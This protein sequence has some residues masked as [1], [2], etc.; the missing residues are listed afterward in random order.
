MCRAH[1]VAISVT[2]SI[3][4]VFLVTGCDSSSNPLGGIGD[5]CVNHEDCEAGLFCGSDGLCYDPGGGDG[6]ADG[7]SD[8]DGDVDVCVDND[9]DTF[10]STTTD[11]PTGTDCNDANA[12]I[13]PE[14]EEVCGDSVDNNCDGTVDESCPCII[15]ALR[16]CSSVG[17]PADLTPEMRCQ[18]GV[19]VCEDGFWSDECFGEV[20]PQEEECNG[21]DD[22]CDG[23]VDEGLLNTLG[24]CDDGTPPP[25]EDCGPTGEGNGIDD[26]GDGQVDETCVCS[27]PDYDPEL[28]R[29][30]QPCYSG[31]IYTLGVGV[32]HGGTRDCGSDGVWGPCIG[33]VIPSEEICG[34]AEDEDCDGFVDET[35]PTC[36][37]PT[38]EV[39]DSVDNDCDGL[40]D[41]GVRNPCGGCGLVSDEETCD[42][43][44]D[45]NC[46]GQIDEG[47]GGCVGGETQACYGG[48]PSAAGVGVC[49]LGERTCTGEFWGDCTGW[50]PPG[51]ELCG[52][53]GLGNGVDED[54]DG[55]EDEDCG[56]AD[57][58]TRFCGDAAGWCEYGLETCG[59]GVWGDCSGEV[60]P[61]IEVCDT[62]DNDCDG[63]TDEGLLNACGTC[64]ESC[65]VLPMDPTD[66]GTIDEGVTTIEADDPENPTGRG[67]ITLTRAAFIPPYLWAANH[68]NNTVTKF[69]TDTHEQEAIYWVGANPSRTA[70]DLNGNMWVGGRDDGRLT[71]VMWNTEECPD[72]NGN[73]SVDTSVVDA[74][75]IP[76]LVNSALDPEADECVLYSAVPNPAQPSIRGVAAGPDGRVW[77]G[78][79]GGGVQSIDPA[80]FVLG[81]YFAGD[82]VP[83]YDPDIDGVMQPTPG[84]TYDSGGVY[85][86][87]VD[88]RGFL[89]TSSFN[90]NTLARFNTLTEE[91]DA[92]YVHAGSQCSY[93]IAVDGNDRIWLGGWPECGGV[94]MFDPDSMRFYSFI[95]PS[96]IG[97][98]FPGE[99]TPA[100]VNDG[101]IGTGG[102]STFYVT[103]V[104]VEPATGDVWC[105]FYPIGYTGRLR[106]NEADY[107]SSSWTLIGTT[108]DAANAYLI[109][110]TADLR[111]VGFDRN[112]YAWTL[113][114]GSDRVWKIDP[115]TNDREATLP[116]GQSIGVGSHYTY[117]DFTGSTALSFTAPRGFW[118]YNFD[119]EFEDAQVDAVY[120]E[121]YVPSGTSAGV[122][123]RALDGTGA[124][125]SDWL[126]VEEGP[127]V[128]GYFDYPSG[129]AF[130]RV[131]LADHGGPLVG[132]GF[133][134]E[135][136]LTTTD[137]DIRP[138][139]HDVRLEWQR[140]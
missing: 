78:Y 20:G 138:I 33:E 49:E 120:W 81:D 75:G 68:T 80:T 71:H 57:G 130:H 94:V 102:S 67:G 45:N 13:H 29:R 14:A 73:G 39:C 21:L 115:A 119:F 69:N 125:I 15:G 24:E 140:P 32:C 66:D 92:I 31:P 70:V 41:E 4:L 23:T 91:W 19:Q 137:R 62:V 83:R 133:D 122:R 42:D 58:E 104:G 12:A 30:G 7:D 34:G 27:V 86:L 52:P 136:R 43:G 118:T 60:G 54:C 16:M 56:C 48:P 123:I 135:V 100:V 79:T 5:P 47:C 128:P 76:I 126:P 77:F 11:C 35:C 97:P 132:R 1:W 117:S 59:G 18:P 38:E 108:R 51:I 124:P 74:G 84:S 112:G 110:V 53:G 111:G 88:S 105:S 98:S 46:N 61:E 82:T 3:Y 101:V 10:F 17:D 116:L 93:G 106:L 139:V 72:R 127:G 109:G 134:I 2:V 8:G 85:G 9:G 131:M 89:Y 22:N 121:A 26:N 40:I 25:P 55:L 103:G 44:L 87:V 6:D 36:T 113:G 64:G 95:V 50:V 65:Y 37:E 99:T 107:Y 96:A 129:E 114:L 28:P 63:L 90:R